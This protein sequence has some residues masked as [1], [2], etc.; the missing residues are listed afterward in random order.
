M[1]EKD[2]QGRVIEKAE[3]SETEIAVWGEAVLV[4]WT[5]EAGIITE[6]TVVDKITVA[7]ALRI[8]LHQVDTAEVEVVLREVTREGLVAPVAALITTDLVE[9]GQGHPSAHPHQVGPLKVER[10]LAEVVE[11]EWVGVVVV[12]QVILGV[13]EDQQ[14]P[15]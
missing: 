8:I 4:E 9:D 6:W 14:R 13:Q 1:P 3:D 10:D 7:N 11:G 15:L 2:P 12:V 5:V